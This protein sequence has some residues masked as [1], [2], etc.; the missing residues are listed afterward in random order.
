VVATAE[1]EAL[2]KEYQIHFFETSAKANLN[3]EEAFLTIATDAVHRMMNEGAAPHTPGA[4]RIGP[5]QKKDRE[6]K[7]C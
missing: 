3:V 7:C 5:G 2:A 6:G 4:Q 1:G